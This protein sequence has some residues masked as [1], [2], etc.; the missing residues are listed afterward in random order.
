MKTVRPTYG[1]CPADLQKIMRS[2][3]KHYAWILLVSVCLLPACSG[4]GLKMREVPDTGNYEQTLNYQFQAKVF[5]DKEGDCQKL[6]VRVRPIN[7][8]YW[9]E[10]P[11]SRL[12]LFDD[13]CMSPVRFERVEYLS[14]KGAGLVRLSGAEVNYFWSEQFRLEDELIGWLWQKGII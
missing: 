6:V 8:V 12:Q 11:P 13:D 14:R 10:A 1:L 7:K 5:A 2:S 4:S 3:A 9:K